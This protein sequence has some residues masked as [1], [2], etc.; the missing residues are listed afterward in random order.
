MLMVSSQAFFHTLV[1]VC[2][3]CVKFQSEL[4]VEGPILSSPF[5]ILDSSEAAL[6][7]EAAF[8][9]KFNMQHCPLFVLFMSYMIFWSARSVATLKPHNI[10]TVRCCTRK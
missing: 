5:S 9:K 1:C 3:W 2:A 4:K 6:H 7:C 8:T 10:T